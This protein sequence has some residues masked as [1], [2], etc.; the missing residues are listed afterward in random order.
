[1]TVTLRVPPAK[2]PFY[3]RREFRVQGAS[4]R[5]GPVQGMWEGVTLGWPAARLRTGHL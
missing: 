2:A 1:M 4:I 5:K 3:P